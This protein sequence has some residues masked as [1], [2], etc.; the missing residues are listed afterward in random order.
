MSPDYKLRFVCQQDPMRFGPAFSGF[1]DAD[2][3]P[4]R[5]SSQSARS[6]RSFAVHGREG[7]LVCDFDVRPTL[8]FFRGVINSFPQLEMDWDPVRN[9]RVW[10]NLVCP[11]LQ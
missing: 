6:G 1:V 8:C 5:Y 9:Q 10:N 11:S 3:C 7:F 2:A 4:A